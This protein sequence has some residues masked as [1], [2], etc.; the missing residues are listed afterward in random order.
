VNGHEDAEPLMLMYEAHPW[1]MTGWR[2]DPCQIQLWILRNVDKVTVTVSWQ[3]SYILRRPISCWSFRCAKVRNWHWPEQGAE[4]NHILVVG[5]NDWVMRWALC[6]RASTSWMYWRPSSSCAMLA[7]CGH[8]GSGTTSMPTGEGISLALAL[9]LPS[10]A[11]ATFK[12]R[13]LIFKAPCTYQ[14]DTGAPSFESGSDIS[15][16]W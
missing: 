4:H 7:L 6:Y 12:H 2:D 3:A 16:T 5:G 13:S 11:R 9:A 8:T 1:G 15:Q 14:D 10:L